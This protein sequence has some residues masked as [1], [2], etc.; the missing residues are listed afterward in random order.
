MWSITYLTIFYV[1][2]LTTFLKFAWSAIYQHSVWF[3]KAGEW[4][5]GKVV[6]SSRSYFHIAFVLLQSQKRKEY[7]CLVKRI[8]SL[9]SVPALTRQ[10]VDSIHPWLF[11][12]C[13]FLYDNRN[14]LEETKPVAAQKNTLETRSVMTKCLMHAV[15]TLRGSRQQ[16]SFTWLVAKPN[17]LG[18]GVIVPH[19]ES[20]DLGY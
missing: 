19:F 4:I 15:S 14:F 12:K 6:L 10:S 11:E 20:Q 2:I 5:N 8:N 1:V 7:L 16:F 9:I 3:A 18:P 13:Y 17:M